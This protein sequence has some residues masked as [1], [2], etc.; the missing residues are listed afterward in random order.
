[1]G[2]GIPLTIPYWIRGLCVN[3]WFYFLFTLLRI[4][5]EPE[6]ESE[7]E[8]CDDEPVFVYIFP[9]F[10]KFLFLFTFPRQRP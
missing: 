6:L 8:Y 5:I 4:E 2:L 1:M 3:T 9:I 10:N 7:K